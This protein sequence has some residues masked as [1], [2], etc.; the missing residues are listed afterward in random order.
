MVD[1][2]LRVPIPVE[3]AEAVQ[4]FTRAYYVRASS[5]DDAL[6]IIAQRVTQEGGEVLSIDPIVEVDRLP[7]EL[8]E[9]AESTGRPGIVWQSGRAFYP[10]D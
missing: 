10:V 6:R 5:A 1:I 4:N 9:R 8:R 3:N 2:R 7:Q